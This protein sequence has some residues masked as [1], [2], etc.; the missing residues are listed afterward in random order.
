ML[1]DLTLREV[2]HIRVSLLGAISMITLSLIGLIV[3]LSV[4]IVYTPLRNILPGY[5]ASLRQQL[6]QESARVDSLQADLT[7]QRQYLD[8]IKATHGR[9]YSVGQ[10]AESRLYATC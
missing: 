3:L 2:F 7:L 1:D 9:R 4:L 8:V 6:I 5:S 10:R